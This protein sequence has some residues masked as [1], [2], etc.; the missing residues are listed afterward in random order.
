MCVH[1]AMLHNVLIVG[2]FEKWGINFMTCHPTSIVDHN[3]IIVV[4]Y[5]FPKWVEAMSTFSNKAETT[6]L[7]ISITL[8]H[9]LVCSNK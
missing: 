9:G 6:T 8:L 5:Y 3:Y 7:F 1:I 4:I 2:P